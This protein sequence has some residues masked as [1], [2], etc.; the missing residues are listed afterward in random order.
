MDSILGSGLTTFKNKL[1][2]FLKFSMLKFKKFIAKV[3]SNLA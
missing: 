3:L 2:I 1:R